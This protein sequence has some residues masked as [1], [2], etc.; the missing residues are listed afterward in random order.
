M[1]RGRGESG[2]TAVYNHQKAGGVLGMGSRSTGGGGRVLLGSAS[3]GRETTHCATSRNLYP[4]TYLCSR[5]ARTAVDRAL[6]LVVDR[7]RYFSIFVV[8]SWSWIVRHE[9]R[10][11]TCACA[12]EPPIPRSDSEHV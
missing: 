2:G 5:C 12:A 7:R 8:L 9:P 1:G 4:Y 3:A 11:P 6:A 10:R